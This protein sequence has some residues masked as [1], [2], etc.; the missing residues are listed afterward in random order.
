LRDRAAEAQQYRASGLALVTAAHALWNTVYHGCALDDFR[1]G[2]EIIVRQ[3]SLPTASGRFARQQQTLPRSSLSDRV[4]DPVLLTVLSCPFYGVTPGRLS[5][6]AGQRGRTA[7]N[8]DARS[9]RR[10]KRRCR[11]AA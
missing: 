8:D 2:G 7:K 9:S 4:P 11:P 3:R 5:D 6:S 10:Q 1:R